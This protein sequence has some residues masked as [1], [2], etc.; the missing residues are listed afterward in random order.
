MSQ[1]YTRSGKTPS[2]QHLIRE[3]FSVRDVMPHQLR[4]AKL[5][6]RRI[7]TT[8]YDNVLETCRRNAGL[9]VE[10]ATVLEKP[11]DFAGNFTVVHLHGFVERLTDQDW[12]QAYVLTDKQY[13]A[14]HLSGSGW[15]ETFRNDVGY[16][17][18]VFFFGYSIGDIDIAR[19][20]FE[21]PS[22]SEK[23]F[24][25]V[26]KTSKDPLKSPLRVTGTSSMKTL[27]T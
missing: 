7:Y 2:L 18:A 12:D 11:A 1:L 16:A 24:I 3:G 5:P 6:W 19:L 10:A 21:N 13:A 25:V 8:N 23:T 17:D 14:N 26:G 27:Q 22:L 4:I 20:M 15:L 9:P